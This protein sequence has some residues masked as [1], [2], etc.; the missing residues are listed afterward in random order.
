[1]DIVRCADGQYV[2][3]ASKNNPIGPI[4]LTFANTSLPTIDETG[5]L[6]LGILVSRPS[7]PPTSGKD[8]MWKID[9]VQLEVAG[10][11]GA[12]E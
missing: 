1:V 9:R 8:P 12:A 7:P 6:L 3:L 5:G 2:P 4:E 10:T 11:A